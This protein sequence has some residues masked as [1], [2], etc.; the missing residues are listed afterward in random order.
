MSDISLKVS[1]KPSDI[2]I[3]RKPIPEFDLRLKTFAKRN[4]LDLKHRFDMDIPPYGKVSVSLADVIRT[5]DRKSSPQAQ[6]T[7]KETLMKIESKNGDTMPFFAHLADDRVYGPVGPIP[8][9][10]T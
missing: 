2:T 1:G 10:G 7:I 5:C 3:P 8:P 9:S 6:A 4:G